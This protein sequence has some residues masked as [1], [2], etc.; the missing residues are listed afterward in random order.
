MNKIRISL[1]VVTLLLLSPKLALATDYYVSPSGVD[2][3]VGS[4]SA[5]WKTIQKSMS[6]AVGGGI[7]YLRSGLYDSPSAD[8][9]NNNVTIRNYPS[10]QVVIK[11]VGSEGFH[12]WTTASNGAK[13][14]IRIIGSDVTPTVLSNGVTSQKGIVIMDVVGSQTK[15]FLANGGCDN[16]EIAGIDFID[17]GDAIFTLKQ[18]NGQSGNLSADNWYVHDNR[19]YRFY[20]ET[21]MQFN[22]DDNLIENNVIIKGTSAI[23]S[24]YGCYLLNLLGHGNI[25]RGNNLD[26]QGGNTTCSGILFEWSQA[27]AN[28]IENNIIIGVKN[29]VESQGGDDNIIRNNT[30]TV[31]GQKF[32]AANY[33]ATQTSWPCDDRAGGSA[34]MLVPPNDPTHVDYLY[35]YPYGECQSLRNIFTDGITPRP[36]PTPSPSSTPTPTPILDKIAPVVKITSPV[37][38]ATITRSKTTTITSTATDNIKL[39][40]LEYYINNVLKCSTTPVTSC[41]WSVPSARSTTYTILV[42]GYDAAGNIGSNTITVKS[43]R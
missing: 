40:K 23:N 3:S 28:L 18:Y 37:T 2:T 14:G 30:M 31:T 25:V 32:V 15:P 20:R 4:V 13:S 17:I 41:R 42:K 24:P 7:I 12:C 22:G 26:N 35:Y 36:T 8:F 9:K 6:N 5:P 33:P 21:G 34:A 38:G 39:T 19:V 1:W 10:E 11:M 43:S 16:W 27:D 29:G